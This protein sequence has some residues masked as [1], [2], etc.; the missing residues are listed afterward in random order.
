MT[1]KQ[2]TLPIDS[3]QPESKTERCRQPSQH[4]NP[5]NLEGSHFDKTTAE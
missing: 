3:E 5:P 2:E 4:T 1:E